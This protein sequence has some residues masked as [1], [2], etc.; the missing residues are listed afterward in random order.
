MPTPPAYAPGEGRRWVLQRGVNIF[1]GSGENNLNIS[2]AW[3]GRTTYAHSANYGLAGATDYVLDRWI[4]AQVRL[5]HDHTPIA[6]MALEPQKE[7][8]SPYIKVDSE[9]MFVQY[10]APPAVWPVTLTVTYENYVLPPPGTTSLGAEMLKW[11]GDV[12]AN[13]PLDS[14]LG[15][16]NPES[17]LLDPLRAGIQLTWPRQHGRVP[18][19]LQA[20]GGL[21]GLT[22]SGRNA[23]WD[24]EK[25]WV[26]D[27]LHLHYDVLPRGGYTLHGEYRFS[28]LPGSDDGSTGTGGSSPAGQGVFVVDTHALDDVAHP[29]G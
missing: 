19:H 24:G 7:S 13:P 3:D 9:D 22:W 16:I 4:Y 8:G 15:S 18:L 5:Y 26:L 2:P 27:G 17:P 25:L 11:V 23:M 20:L 29:I 28:K 21:G 10:S 6:L 1:T 12:W 14:S